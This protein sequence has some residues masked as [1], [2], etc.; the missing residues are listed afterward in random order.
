[1][2]LKIFNVDE[3]DILIAEF[4]LTENLGVLRLGDNELLEDMSPEA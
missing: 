1:M 2:F 4:D 3:G